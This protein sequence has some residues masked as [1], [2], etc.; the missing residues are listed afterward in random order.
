MFFTGTRPIDTCHIT[1]TRT[2]QTDFGGWASACADF[3]DAE[4]TPAGDQSCCTPSLCQCNVL[5]SEMP[6]TVYC[7]CSNPVLSASRSKVWC[8]LQAVTLLLLLQIEVMCKRHIHGGDSGAIGGCHNT[9]H[10]GP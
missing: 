1:S 2:Q 4:Q 9:G 7:Q 6:D 3:T 5:I 8:K 10:A